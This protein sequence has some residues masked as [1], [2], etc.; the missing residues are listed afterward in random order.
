MNQLFALMESICENSG[1]DVDFKID[2][3]TDC[4][5]GGRVGIC[6]NWPHEPTVVIRTGGKDSPEAVAIE[7]LINAFNF[8]NTN[9]GYKTMQ[10]N[11]TTSSGKEVVVNIS[12]EGE[13][14]SVVIEGVTISE[15]ELLEIAEYVQDYDMED[16][17]SDPS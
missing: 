15:N 1:L 17:D 10:E 9:G 4:C 16:D 12:D 5:W 7:L 14:E 13:P 11:F 3:A 8:I 6:E 2:I